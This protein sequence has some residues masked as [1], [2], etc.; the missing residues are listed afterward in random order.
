MSA[1]MSTHQQ[2]AEV[3]ALLTLRYVMLPERSDHESFTMAS[4]P[5]WATAA[6]RVS[7]ACSGFH[8]H[9]N[10]SPSCSSWHNSS[11]SPGSANT[12]VCGTFSNALS[13]HSAKLCL[14]YCQAVVT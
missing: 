12:C 3:D 2:A 11:S 4:C 10:V 5:S 7:C 9:G 1:T 14:P 8:S 13:Y 6:A